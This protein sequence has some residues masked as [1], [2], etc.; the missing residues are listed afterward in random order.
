MAISE[1]S[2]RLHWSAPAVLCCRA[3]A[4]EVIRPDHLEDPLL[5]PELEAG[6][7]LVVP[8]GA[9]QVGEAIGATLRQTVEGLTALTPELVVGGAV[10]EAGAGVPARGAGATGAEATGVETTGAGVTGA[11]S[12]GAARGA[13][14]TGAARGADATRAEE[15]GASCSRRGA[16]PTQRILRTLQQRLFAVNALV[17]GDHTALEEG[18]LTLRQSLCEEALQVDPLLTSVRLEVIPPEQRRRPTNTILDV[19]PVATKVAG[20]LGEGVS[21]G[22][23]G[24][25]VLLTGAEEGGAQLHEF[26]ASAGCLAETVCFG[27]P[28]SPD[29]GDLILRVDVRIQKGAGM[30]R[31][32]PF[33]AHKACNRIVQELR[34]ILKRAP[35]QAAARVLTHHDLRR[36]GRPRVL[37][38]KVVMGQGAMHEKLLL[39]TEPVGVAGGRRTID[40]GNLPLVLTANE[41]R[42]GAVHALT[43]VG[44]ASKETSRHYV[45]E[46]L[47][48]RLAADEA[49]DLLGVALIGSPH[50]N[51][52]KLY[53]AARLG[54][55][56]EA[57]DVDGA[58]V[59]TE[60]FGNNHIDFAACIAQI[61]SRGIPVVGLTYAADQGRL[62][63]GNPF[64]D[65]LVE[66]NKDPDG[67]ENEVVAHNTLCPEDAERAVAML[68]TKLAGV[69]IRPAPERWSPE[70]IAANQALV[71]AGVAAGS[72]AGLRSEVP[73]PTR[74][75]AVFTPLAKPL[76][77]CVVALC[78]AGGVHLRS[79][80]PFVLAGDGSFRE[81]PA[82][83]PARELMVSHGGFDN[84]DVNRDINA[85][86]PIERLRELAAEAIIGAVAPVHIGF[87][88][89]GGDV[90]RF[91]HDTGPA[92]AR[93]LQAEGVD[94]AVFT[95]GCGTCHRSAVIVQRAVEAAGIATV[96][97]AALP[98][99]AQQEGAPRITAPHVPI[100][101]NAGEPGNAAMQR[102]IL[103][104]SLRAVAELGEFGQVKELAFT[105]R[106]EG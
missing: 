5:F 81:I 55:L 83:T 31:R 8:A 88:G 104:E 36:P 70:V 102:G 47:L 12:S 90:E 23:A 86:F 14:A 98:P 91:R 46:P 93:L 39:P 63:V 84:S 56:V 11:A 42:D 4:G 97:I 24:M 17:I 99:I 87:M 6:G 43:C 95:G 71:A 28:G 78:T 33:A 100:G 34:E 18:R 59:S 41:L 66:L 19:I 53:G 74:P 13:G 58:F 40:L 92:I 44:P 9:L 45:R 51:D 48:E 60:G 38:V 101:A 35:A 61:G 49:L 57:L 68:K 65:A 106:R 52:D 80:E 82:A 1:H 30:E 103:L 29:P 15:A 54:A 25:V 50:S 76:S 73:V 85:M 16:A 7:L 94:V 2:A 26:G 32:G 64:M 96:I 21:H 69:P 37:L 72:V 27:R 89:G 20:R 22:L 77:Q 75:P 3:A 79:Q 62:V 67:R 105:Y 10:G